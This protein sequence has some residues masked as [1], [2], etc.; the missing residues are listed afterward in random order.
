LNKKDIFHFNLLKNKVALTFL[1]ENTAPSPIEKWKGE[2]IISFQEDLF[3]KV[4]GRVSE[5]WFYTYFKN[6]SEKLP[7]I[8]M[9]N[10]LCKYVG[11]DNWNTFKNIHPYKEK[12]KSV[13]NVYAWLAFPFLCILSFI[14]YRNN[15]T[16]QFNFCFVDT[17]KNEAITKTFLDIKVLQENE[18]P[19]HFKT[20]SLGCFEYTSKND[21]IKFVIQSPY[22]K[23]DTI[24]RYISSN[25]NTTVKLDTDD[26]A[27][28][29]DYYANG[30]TKNRDK[31]KSQLDKMI[32]NDAQ[33]YQL[34]GDNIGIEVYTK[35]DFIRL[36]T[37]PTRVVKQIRV[38]EK[39]M[40]N[41]KIV[42]LKFVVK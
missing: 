33:I 24:I 27:L 35:E 16:N 26:Y 3:T 4:K 17:I 6:T 1:K 38:L 2:E 29:L 11:F 23:T 18:S 19:L 25:T 21:Y 30:N 42:K 13:K 34:F 8:D 39:K 10:L 15:E 32:A 12:G 31:H 36:T 9:L 37:I 22:H 7:R 28:L 14:V 41:G 40:E 20:D 5:K